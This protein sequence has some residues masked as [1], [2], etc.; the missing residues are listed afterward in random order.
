[1]Q[2][3]CAVDYQKIIVGGLVEKYRKEG[4]V[5]LLPLS[6]ESVVLLAITRCLACA[7]TRGAFAKDIE[8]SF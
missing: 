1:M 7:T 8:D 6:M 2:D 3:D 4:A 5:Y